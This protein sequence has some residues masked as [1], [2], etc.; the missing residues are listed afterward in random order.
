MK[1]VVLEDFDFFGFLICILRAGGGHHPWSSLS[2]VY[3]SFVYFQA[4]A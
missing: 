4:L 2:L 3:S 1:L